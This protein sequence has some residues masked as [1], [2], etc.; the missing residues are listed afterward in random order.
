[1]TVSDHLGH[2]IVSQPSQQH[3]VVFKGDAGLVE[4]DVAATAD[5]HNLQIH[6]ALPG[7]LVGISVHDFCSDPSQI[8]GTRRAADDHG[9]AFVGALQ[10]PVVGMVFHFG[11]ESGFV[12]Q[13]APGYICFPKFFL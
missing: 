5:S 3:G 1:M 10:G 13:R 4:S 7:D 12:D 9:L 6:P 2:C 11:R 8:F